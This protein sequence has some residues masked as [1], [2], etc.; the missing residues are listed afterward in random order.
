MGSY[1]TGEAW[2]W[3]P[4]LLATGSGNVPGTL[5]LRNTIAAQAP[6]SPANSLEGAASAKPAARN[7]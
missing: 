6:H 3:L 2:A 4:E 1:V 7:A 5:A